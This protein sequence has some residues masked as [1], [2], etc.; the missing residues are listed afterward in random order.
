MHKRRPMECG[1][2][3]GGGD[4]SVERW[5]KGKVVQII[6]DVRTELVGAMVCS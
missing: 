2:I 3:I 6:H 5:V 4:G 1:T